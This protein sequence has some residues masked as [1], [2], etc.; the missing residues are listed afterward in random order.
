[1]AEEAVRTPL[2]S[3]LLTWVIPLFSPLKSTDLEGHTINLKQALLYFYSG[4][5][6]SCS[7]KT[8]SSTGCLLQNQQE[9]PR[10]T[11][12]PSPV[13]TLDQL[14]S[15]APYNWTHLSQTR[16]QHMLPCF[17]TK[18]YGIDRGQTTKTMDTNSPLKSKWPIT[19]HHK[20]LCPPQL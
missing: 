10:R 20:I 7:W 1:M 4:S 3:A 9:G 17:L 12:T 5:C 11:H 14:D 2:Y 19:S 6:L 8:T 16:C 15:C 13:T 18:R